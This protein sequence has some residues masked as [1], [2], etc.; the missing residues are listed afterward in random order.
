[1]KNVLLIINIVLICL[2]GYLYYLHFN[3]PKKFDAHL[4][5]SITGSGSTEKSELAYI[6]LD[7]LQN[8]YTYYK[9]IKAELEQKQS[10]ANDENG[11]MQKK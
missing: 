7:S 4:S 9:K 5:P 2:V 6:D 3:A 1:M 11:G 10:A 8:N